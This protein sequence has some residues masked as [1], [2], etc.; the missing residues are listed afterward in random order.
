MD[1]RSPDGILAVRNALEAGFP[2]IGRMG[3][4]TF[5]RG[6]HYILLRG[7]DAEGKVMVND[8]A[9]EERSQISYDLNA[10]ARQTRDEQ[11]FLILTTTV[12]YPSESF[13][14]AQ[15]EALSAAPEA[16]YGDEQ[17]EADAGS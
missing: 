9:S 16:P 4:G 10:I 17:P 5:T 7:F 2:V 6:G 12:I 14:A 11:S 13:L 3:S 1:G 15:Q 8:P